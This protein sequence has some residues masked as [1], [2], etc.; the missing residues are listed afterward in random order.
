MN[1]INDI[2]GRVNELYALVTNTLNEFLGSINNLISD[3]NALTTD[4]ML[5]MTLGG[6][7]YVVGDTIYL[8][9]YAI[10][11]LG[12]G[13]TIFMLVKGFIS[14]ISSSIT[15]GSIIKK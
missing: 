11:L 14:R 6:F 2:L 13:F 15:I 9:Y 5:S 4:S 8:M 7:R 3:V 1:W 12:V 10:M